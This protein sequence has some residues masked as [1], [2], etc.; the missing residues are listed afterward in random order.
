MEAIVFD[1]DGV[2][3]FSALEKSSVI[4]RVLDKHD[5]LKIEWVEKIL[6]LW[7]NRKKILEEIFLIKEFNKWLVLDE[8]NYELWLLEK[9]SIPNNKIIDFIKN[10]YKNYKIFTNTSLPHISLVYILKTLQIDE[11]FVEKFSYDTWD[12]LQNINKIINKYEI[13]PEKIL[14]IDDNINHI[15]KLRSTWVNLLYYINSNID[16]NDYL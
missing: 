16:L 2:I 7:L 11:C 6:S 13:E 4:K 9:N 12:K 10:N 14:F 15:E 5:L 1:V 8:I 3:I